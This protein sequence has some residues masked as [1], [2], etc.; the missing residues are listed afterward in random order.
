MPNYRPSEKQTFGFYKIP[1]YHAWG[2]RG[3]AGFRV[4]PQIL[5]PFPPFPLYPQNPPNGFFWKF[6]FQAV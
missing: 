3:F 6:L 5:F 1:K 4:N 2:N